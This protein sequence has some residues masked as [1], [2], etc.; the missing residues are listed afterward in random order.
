MRAALL[1]AALLCAGAAQAE[2]LT[3]GVHLA[4]QHLPAREGQNNVNP[5]L[6][7]RA[8]AWTVGGYHNTYRETTVYAARTLTTWRGVQLVG[9]IAYGYQLH[10]VAGREYGASRGAITPMAGIT[11]APP[12]RVFG[13]QPRIWLLPPT[14]KNSGVVH[15]SLEY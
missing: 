15:L 5:G 10:T 1:L 12:V 2:P 13:A 6:Y 11:Y 9:G 7:V 4:S 8:D 3:I 14:P